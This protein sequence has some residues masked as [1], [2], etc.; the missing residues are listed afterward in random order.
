MTDSP[1]NDDFKLY[2]K[3]YPFNRF[4]VTYQV[5]ASSYYLPRALRMW[6]AS[7]TTLNQN[8]YYASVLRTWSDKMQHFESI[9]KGKCLFKYCCVLYLSV[10][11]LSG[12]GLALTWSRYFFNK[13]KL[14]YDTFN[15]TYNILLLHRLFFYYSI[16]Y[17]IYIH[18]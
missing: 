2:N 14:P 6:D 18:L 12:P 1:F 16:V 3:L 9:R 4:R 7:Y 5:P 10:S 15:F 11:D 8:I 17:I 13:L